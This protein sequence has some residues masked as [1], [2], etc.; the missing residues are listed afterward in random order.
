M[1]RDDTD[2]EYE[3]STRQP[4]PR[5]VHTV[6]GDERPA[7]RTY[8]DGSIDCPYCSNAIAVGRDDQHLS[9]GTCPN[10]WCDASPVWNPDALQARRDKLAQQRLDAERRQRDHQAA[11]A[12]IAEDQREYFAWQQA[13]MEEARRR[14]CCLRCLFTRGY[15]QARFVRHRKACPKESR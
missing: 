1:N 11:M 13:Q 8:E 6:L 7:T 14:G 5:L 2:R 12:R 10:P 4:A 15:R 3:R 9:A